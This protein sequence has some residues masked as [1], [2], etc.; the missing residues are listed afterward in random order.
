MSAFV[1]GER[2]SSAGGLSGGFGAL[3]PT[4]SGA[5]R[6]DAQVGGGDGQGLFEFLLVRFGRV[7]AP[8]PSQDAAARRHTGS[9]RQ[10][11]L[12]RPL[13]QRVALPLGLGPILVEQRPLDGEAPKPEVIVANRAFRLL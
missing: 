3:H 9:V 10:R 1:T 12:R 13:E 4:Q 5:Q 11:F 7:P 6:V 2:G 8:A